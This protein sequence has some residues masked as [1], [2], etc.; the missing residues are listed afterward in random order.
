MKSSN[1]SKLNGNIQELMIATGSI[2]KLHIGKTKEATRWEVYDYI[3]LINNLT[4]LTNK[5]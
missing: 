3:T 1:K 4:S 2:F 5:R